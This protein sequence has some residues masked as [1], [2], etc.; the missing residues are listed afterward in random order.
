M[1][2]WLNTVAD[3]PGRRR[4]A[5]TPANP[6]QTVCRHRCARGFRALR[7]AWIMF[8]GVIAISQ[9]ALIGFH[10]VVRDFE[11]LLSV[12]APRSGRL[13]RHLLPEASEVAQLR[14][15]IPRR[16]PPLLLLHRHRRPRQKKCDQPTKTARL[17][18]PT[19]NVVSRRGHGAPSVRILPQSNAASSIASIETAD[20]SAVQSPRPGSIASAAAATVA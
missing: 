20:R 14:N 3:R 17:H 15:S 5:A 8:R 18:K 6:V 12:E 10:F 2:T 11:F 16:Q 4:N 13:H 9:L 7:Q 19:E 1:P